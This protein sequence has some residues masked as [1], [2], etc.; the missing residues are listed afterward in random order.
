MTA[1]SRVHITDGLTVSFPRQI[2]T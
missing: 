1:T 2:L